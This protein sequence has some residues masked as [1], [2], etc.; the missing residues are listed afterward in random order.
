MKQTL[1]DG[2]EWLL[3]TLLFMK[4]LIQ[5]QTRLTG[6]AEV[7]AQPTAPEP[8]MGWLMLVR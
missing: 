7:S 6:A 3:L 5:V 2:L 8:W 4:P 1:N